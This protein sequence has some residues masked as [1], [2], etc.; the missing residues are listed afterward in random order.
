[1]AVSQAALL[2]ILLMVF[3]GPPKLRGR[4][5]GRHYRPP[6]GTGFFERVLGRLGGGFLLGR[7]KEDYRAILRSYV[8]TLTVQ[9]GWVMIFPEHSQQLLIGNL[10][11][12]EFHLDHFRVAGMVRA[13]V[14]I[15]GLGERSSHIADGSGSN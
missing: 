15:A 14:L 1:M 10:R 12:I 9:R 11:R 2:Q 8:R 3:F 6:V 13:D 5:Y 7:V 4:L